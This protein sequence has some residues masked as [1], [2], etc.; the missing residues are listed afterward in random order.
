[1]SEDDKDIWLLW[2]KRPRNEPQA[3][4]YHP[5]AC[6]L[7]DVASVACALWDEVLPDPTKDWVAASLGV[8]TLA[9]RA[10]VRFWAG[11]HDIGKA[12]PAFQGKVEGS[13]ACLSA[14]GF[15][16]PD[17]NQNEPHG[18]V[19]AM[20]LRKEILPEAYGHH[21]TVAT[22]VAAMVG[23]HHGVIPSAG[24]FKRISAAAGLG[25]WQRA[26]LV[27]SSMLAQAIDIA[28]GLSPPTALPNA[29]AM[30]L[31]GLISV[32]D[33][34]GSDERHYPHA[35][36][37]VEQARKFD[38]PSYCS[39]ANARA[40]NTL[41]TL[42]WTGWNP[43]RTPA[44]FAELFPDLAHFPLRPVQQAAIDLGEQ[45]PDGPKL[46]IIEAPMCEGKTEAAWYLADRWMVTEGRGGAYFALPTQ[47]TSDG[48]LRRVI[49]FLGRR[50]P[51]SRVNL[52]L[53]H[54]RAVLSDEFRA[55]LA[56]A[57][58]TLAEAPTDIQPQDIEDGN[59]WDGASATVVA[60]E[61][62]TYRK[63]GLLAPYGVGT[64]DQALLAALQSKHVF[65]RHFG[66]AGKTVIV[67]EVHAYDTYMT[68]LLE[69]L[70]SWL[71]ALNTSIILLSATLPARRR[72]ILM[73]AYAQGLGSSDAGR[74]PDA[75][76][77]YPR[78]SWLSQKDG[79][80][81][82]IAHSATADKP[83]AIEWVDGQIPADQGEPFSLATSLVEA[84]TEG[85][86]VA[87]ICSTID[88]A[89]TMY[90]S[91][92]TAFS[93]STEDRRPNML[94]LHSRFPYHARAALEQTI[95]RQFGKLVNGKSPDRPYRAIL[96]ST[97]I[98]EQSLDLDFDLMVSD[99]APID[100]LLQRL[101]RLH[102]H[103]RSPRPERVN[104][105]VLWLCKPEL[106]GD[107]PTFDGGTS[108]IYDN[109]VLLRS[110]MALQRKSRD[111]P[112]SLPS[113]IETLVEAV[114]GDDTYPGDK[115][116]DDV[117]PAL[118][119]RWDQTLVEYKC[120][121]EKDRNEAQ[122]R[123]L[124]PVESPQE[125]LGEM[126]LQPREEDAPQWHQEFQAITRLGRP[127]VTL[128]CLFEPEAR[129]RFKPDG[130][131][132]DLNQQPSLEDTQA[133]LRRSITVTQPDL[134]R[135]FIGQPAPSGWR[136]S[137]LL[138]HCR[139][140]IFSADGIWEEG[141]K[142]LRLD[143]TLGIVIERGSTQED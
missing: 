74:V 127:S 88:R 138:R 126:V 96:V 41:Q 24:H 104:K 113:E 70:L 2:A 89:Q 71:A 45:Q 108:A 51:E 95:L 115:C 100:L 78:I 106:D 76:A 37:D 8:D 121:I 103:E 109:H 42:G 57:K 6:H 134:F 137:P 131:A 7:L 58:Q 3:T 84:L 116:P 87:V 136:K 139:P 124:R 129:P 94:L 82:E 17:S 79:G 34:I 50:Y 141:R 123:W 10:W 28:P 102:R 128:I 64:V 5:L 40:L 15:Y 81:L 35:A 69:R 4:N 92:A 77:K 55:R 12:S 101:G 44:S 22:R 66:L 130:E 63:R 36:A 110:W 119:A 23:G 1:M 43:K 13:I 133:L 67:D 142:R 91:L 30:F 97:Q 90:R 135:H 49:S 107:V 19:S 56:A 25:K 31:A 93:A 140:L 99:M 18:L 38:W 111:H 32:A 53:L 33:W 125:D 118:Q 52:Q 117:S 39:S 114:Y 62:F 14:V 122:H 60:G 85:G 47:A 105:P 26:R 54:G 86:C 65:V 80:A 68:A 61:W 21:L 132:V 11:L 16:F 72:Q 120:K 20:A 143:D 48:M 29:V 46:V 83:V 75:K 59:A 27:L 9:A 73:Q 112:L 98:I